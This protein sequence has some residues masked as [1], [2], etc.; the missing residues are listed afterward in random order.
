MEF[1]GADSSFGVFAIPKPADIGSTIANIT[2]GGNLVGVRNTASALATIGGATNIPQGRLVKVYQFADTMTWGKGKHSLVFGAEYKHLV[3]KVPF[4]PLY[5]GPFTFS[6]ASA[7]TRL[8]NN[9]PS[10]I[11]LTAGEPVTTYTE[12][13]QYYFLQDDFKIRPNLTLNL[14]VRYEYTGQPIN[15]LHDIT[16]GPRKRFAEGD[17]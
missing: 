17:F 16:V 3:N 12:N 14:G 2:F 5:Q 8:L 10:A 9:A 7:V 11:S 1:G 15:Q 13:D 4:L 6:T